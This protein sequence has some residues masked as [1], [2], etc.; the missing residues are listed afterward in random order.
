MSDK[1]P[2]LDQT[3]K[4]HN[5][6][7]VEND[8]N[9]AFLIH[10]ALSKGGCGTS[11]VCRNPSEAKSYLRGAGMYADR[12]RFPLPHVVIT[13]LRMGNESGIELVQWI[14][15]QEQPLK[16]VPVVILTGS[17]SDLQFDAAEKVGAQRVCR[18]PGKLEDL[19]LLLSS[20][21]GDFCGS[22]NGKA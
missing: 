6:L 8:P 18:K 22:T 5:F 2:A 4:Q 10:R 14:R 19:E 16:D 15:E 7:I 12:R 9:D 20:I 21:A 17:A 3:P 11:T 1:F 13:D